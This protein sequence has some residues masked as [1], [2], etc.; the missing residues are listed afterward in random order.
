MRALD[1]RYSLRNSD[2]K[3][4]KIPG[5]VMYRHHDEKKEDY[6]Y[7]DQAQFTFTKENLGD[8]AKIYI[9][10]DGTGDPEHVVNINQAYYQYLSQEPYEL[11]IHSV[12]WRLKQC[13]LTSK[14]AQ[15]VEAI[16]LF[17][18][19]ENNTNKQLAVYFAQGLGEHY[20]GT[21][22]NYYS[23]VVYIPA[24]ISL[25]GVDYETKKMAQFYQNT[26]SK[27]GYAHEHKHALKIS[28][29]LMQ[30]GSSN[31]SDSLQSKARALPTF[32]EIIAAGTVNITEIF[33]SE[34]TEQS[35]AQITPF[36]VF[37]DEE[38]DVDYDAEE[39]LPQIQ[40]QSTALIVWQDRSM[41][42]FFKYIQKVDKQNNEA[43]QN[44]FA[45]LKL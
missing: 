27:I 31:A 41:F 7:F 32:K 12:A 9:L 35:V 18:C 23:A 34:D 5:I 15:N 13:G 4:D 2:G 40:T 29:A 26:V 24:L 25:N 17:I 16:N 10:A 43:L 38:T 3:S 36:V 37:P 39:V 45:L 6:E 44:E 11:S 8:Q 19:D 30:Q 21:T 20:K 28:D 14:L 22:I 1:W 33:D 42:S